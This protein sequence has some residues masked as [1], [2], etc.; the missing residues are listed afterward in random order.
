MRRS[1]Y[2][3]IMQGMATLTTEEK[4]EWHF[5]KYWDGLLIHINDNEYAYCKCKFKEEQKK[6]Y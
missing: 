6:K 3:N 2:V 1:R 4:K 5:C